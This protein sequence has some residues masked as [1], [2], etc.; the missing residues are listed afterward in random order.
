[1]VTADAAWEAPGRLGE[2]VEMI[3]ESRGES[4]VFAVGTAHRAGRFLEYGTVRRPAAPWLWP[5]FRARLPGVK[6]SLRN[7]VRASFGSSS[8]QF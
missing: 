2:T 5:V 6:R 7:S 1:M 8:K 4:T 3:D